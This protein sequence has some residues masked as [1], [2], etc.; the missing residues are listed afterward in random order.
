MY[1]DDKVSVSEGCKAAMTA[2][3]RH[4]WNNF[5]ESAEI[6]HGKEKGFK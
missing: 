5:R 1:V 4:G 6:L 2:R 3:T